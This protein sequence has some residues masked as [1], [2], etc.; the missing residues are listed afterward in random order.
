MTNY[1]LN[2]TKF[3]KPAQIRPSIH[4]NLNAKTKEM[5]RLRAIA[6]NSHRLT[7]NHEIFLHI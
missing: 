3:V 1:V 2:R 4:E 5:L 6:K 7:K